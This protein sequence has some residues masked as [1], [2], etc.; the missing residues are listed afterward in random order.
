M[1]GVSEEARLARVGEVRKGSAGGAAG[2]VWEPVEGWRNTLGAP[3]AE[4][5]GSRGVGRVVGQVSGSG[6][7]WASVGRYAAL[8]GC[9]IMMF[10]ERN[11]TCMGR[12]SGGDGDGCGV[13]LEVWG[14][15]G[16]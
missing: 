5:A 15:G 2:E 9:V 13:G 10:S 12:V 7:E 4:V 11:P 14:W 8:S 6:G 3:R 16:S 1:G